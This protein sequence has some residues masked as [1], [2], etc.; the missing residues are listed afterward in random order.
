MER[1][2]ISRR[3]AINCFEPLMLEPND[4]KQVY[5]LI[6]LHTTYPTFSG[7][8]TL[9]L[10]S[11]CSWMNSPHDNFGAGIFQR[12]TRRLKRFL[13]LL[14]L[15]QTCLALAQM[16]AQN[17]QHHS[18]ADDIGDRHVPAERQP[19]A[20]RAA[21]RVECGKCHTGGRPKP[22][23]RT[24]NPDRIGEKTPIISALLQGQ[25]GERNIVENRGNEAEAEC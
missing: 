12:R 22:H 1:V 2:G 5:H 16:P 20:R 21:T 8:S 4:H 9:S 3:S 15:S 7:T 6:A 23:N 10:V 17:S 19:A 13:L 24:T 25:R 14:F 11:R 18:E